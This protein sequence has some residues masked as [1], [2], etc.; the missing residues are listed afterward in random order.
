[1]VLYFIKDAFFQVRVFQFKYI[2]NIKLY[3]SGT[4]EILVICS[5]ELWNK[6]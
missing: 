6:N 1:M 5:L 4:V 3:I 2:V